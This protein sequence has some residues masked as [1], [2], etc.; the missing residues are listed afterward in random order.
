MA[1][2]NSDPAYH[3]GDLRNALVKAGL[4]V[5]IER[6]LDGVTMR[7]VARRAGVSHAAPYRHF[8]DRDAL[9]ATVAERGFNLLREMIATSTNSAVNEFDALCA[10]LRAYLDF[11]C[12]YPYFTRVM[13]GMDLSEKRPELKQVALIAFEE[14]VSL[15]R[16]AMPSLDKDHTRSLALALWAEV[17]GLVVLSSTLKLQDLAPGEHPIAVSRL[18]LQRILE[19]I[20]RTELG[21]KK[22]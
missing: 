5:L 9:L 3:H 15:V 17:H 18:A 4:A 11:G 6:G 1:T 20:S 7:E 10:A 2:S 13:F 14:L 16:S 8:I 12:E 21:V 22:R 19:I